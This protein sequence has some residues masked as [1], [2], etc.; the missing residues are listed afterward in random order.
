MLKKI[1]VTVLSSIVLLAPVSK[2]VGAESISNQISTQKAKLQDRQAELSTVQNE[3][4]QLETTIKTLEKEVT[5][6]KEKLAKTN[7]SISKTKV[8]IQ[9]KKDKIELLQ[10]K[11]EKREAILKERLVAMQ[12]QPKVNLFTK[13]ILGSSN[14]G[15]MIERIVSINT[16][17]EADNQIVTQQKQEQDLLNTEKEALNQKEQSLIELQENQ[18]KEEK[19]LLEKQGEQKKALDEAQSKMESLVQEVNDETANLRELERQALY[20]QQQI[21]EQE[22]AN[23]ASNDTANSSSNNSSNGSANN[24]SN[25]SSNGSSNNSSNNSSNG[26]TNNT[27]K[28]STNP[29]TVTP[30]NG[31]VVSYAMQFLGVPYV[32]GGVS[33]SGFDCSGFVYY[34]FKNNGYNISRGGVTTYWSQVKKVSNPV[35]GDLVFLQNTYKPGPSHIGIY[36]GNGQMI[37]AGDK[38][39]SIANLNS[40]YNR[41]HF[42]GYGRF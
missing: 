39:I 23:D 33:P 42:L 40:S 3:I 13:V 11:V 10:T 35:P 16:L 31:D 20:I 19:A 28:P 12:E 29:G 5:E 9:E 41:K 26:S 18:K 25:N 30:G 38:G 1:A 7:D 37:H 17:F 36:I 15:D 8:E 4:N 24:S 22:E 34:V 32:F 2:H 6:A 27:Q 14:I 21:Q